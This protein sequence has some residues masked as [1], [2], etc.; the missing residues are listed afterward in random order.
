MGRKKKK[1][2]SSH[3]DAPAFGQKKHKHKSKSKRVRLG[4][5]GAVGSTK[6]LHKARLILE[7]GLVKDKCCQ[8]R[9]RCLKCPTVV[10]RLTK[11]DALQL[12]EAAFRQA[13]TEARRR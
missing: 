4:E 8:D 1:S 2:L 3:H 10:H 13:L 12:D 6:E 7:H 9:P 11:R 5:P